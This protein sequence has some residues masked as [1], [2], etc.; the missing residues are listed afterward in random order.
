MPVV[1]G[2]TE[3]KG[4][5]EKERI[6]CRNGRR[7]GW[8]EGMEG[9]GWQRWRERQGI[10]ERLCRGKKKIM[11]ERRKDWWRRGGGG[12]E[13]NKEKKKLTTIF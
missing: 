4:G 5:K 2:I 8:T 13:E 10:M 7:K 11:I 9:Y 3:G 1:V 12:K 6:A